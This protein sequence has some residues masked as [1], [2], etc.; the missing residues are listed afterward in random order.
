LGLCSIT[1]FNKPDVG[2]IGSSRF[3]SQKQV[4]KHYSLALSATIFWE[5]VFNESPIFVCP[6]WSLKGIRLRSTR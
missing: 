2:I 4:K 3:V 6:Y 1:D 5:E